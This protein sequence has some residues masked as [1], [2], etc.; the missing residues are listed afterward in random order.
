MN[1]EDDGKNTE[2][3]GLTGKTVTMNAIELQNDLDIKVVGSGSGHSDGSSTTTLTREKCVYKSV[4]AGDILVLQDYIKC[5]FY[6]EEDDLTIFYFQNK[7]GEYSG[8]SLDFCLTKSFQGDLTDSFNEGD[9]VRISG[10]II[11]LN[12]TANNCDYEFE[13]YENNWVDQDYFTENRFVP[14]NENC[15]EKV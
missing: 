11:Y 10:K 9:E 7:E 5:L 3:N 15:I 8:C 14:L 6:D 1:A 2:N 13:I 4:K 12:F